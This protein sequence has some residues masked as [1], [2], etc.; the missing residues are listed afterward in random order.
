MTKQIP[1]IVTPSTISVM[2]DGKTHVINKDHVNFSA[3]KNA[4]KEK[5]FDLIE[6]LVNVSNAI[7]QFGQGLVD[8]QNGVVLF[9]GKPLHNSLTDRILGMIREGW[10]VTPL[11]AFLNNLMQN[12]SKRAVDELY[13]F[14]EKTAIPI[15]DDGHFLAY[16]KVKNDYYDFYSGTVLHTPGKVVKMPRNQVDENKDVTCSTGLHFCSLSYLPHYWGGRGKVLVVK[17]NPKDVVS[18]PADYNNAKGRCCEYLVV[19]ETNV[20]ETNEW[21]TKTVYDNVGTKHG[22]DNGRKQGLA[23]YQQDLNNNTTMTQ[24]SLDDYVKNMDAGDNFADGF[25]D[26]Y[27]FEYSTQDKNTM[28]G[29]FNGENYAIKMFNEDQAQA[30]VKLNDELLGVINVLNAGSS[31]KDGF[32]N[33][34]CTLRDYQ[35]GPRRDPKTGRFAKGY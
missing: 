11:V 22:Y 31:F 23:K 16:K 26:G 15:T 5:K 24:E 2:L 21:F 9:D 29:Y 7:K 14:L 34:Y 28:H 20:E 12:P 4:L 27:M 35:T 32:Y 1:S 13:G 18:I 10:D 25:Y 19:Q 8:V 6:N 30:H 17:I 3:I 33:K